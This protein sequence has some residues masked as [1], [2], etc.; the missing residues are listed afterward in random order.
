M[1]GD[2]GFSCGKSALGAPVP[3]HGMAGVVTAPEIDL[4]QG[5]LFGHGL[6]EFPVRVD[7]FDV[8]KIINAV[9]MRCRLADLLPLINERNALQEIEHGCQVGRGFIPEPA[10]IRNPGEHRRLVMVISK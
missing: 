9:I 8:V 4:F 7:A 10:V 2:P 5:V 1:H 3:W 6:H